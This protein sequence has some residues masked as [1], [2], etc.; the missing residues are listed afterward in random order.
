MDYVTIQYPFT[1]EY[2]TVFCR[3]LVLNFFSRLFVGLFLI[4]LFVFFARLFLALFL[5]LFSTLITHG[6]S[7]F[8]IVNDWLTSWSV[9]AALRM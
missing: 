2:R 8:S 7:P 3:R 1:A 9:E 4:D 5:V 6:K